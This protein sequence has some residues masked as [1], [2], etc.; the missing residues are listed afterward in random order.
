MH[1]KN[2]R[3]IKVEGS[4]L[5][6]INRTFNMIIKIKFLINLFFWNQLKKIPY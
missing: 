6:L 2:K 5:L 4:I 1:F 3:S